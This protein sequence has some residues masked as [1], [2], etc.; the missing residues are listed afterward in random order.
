MKYF[1]M[2]SSFHHHQ[3]TTCTWN[4]QLS[5]ISFIWC[6]LQKPSIKQFCSKI[7]S[8]ATN[9]KPKRV[10]IKYEKKKLKMN[11][12]KKT[13]AIIKSLLFENKIKI[14]YTMQ[15]DLYIFFIVYLVSVKMVFYV[16][17]FTNHFWHQFSNSKW[18]V[19]L[20]SQSWNWNK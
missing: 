11:K 1:I 16:I 4:N 14:N 17:C 19:L 8:A 9:K 3:H 13:Q 18:F 5:L 7:I 10:K 2:E 6:M 12:N 20:H 15:N